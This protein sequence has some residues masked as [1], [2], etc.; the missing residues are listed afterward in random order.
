MDVTRNIIRYPWEDHGNVRT[1][2][3]DEFG[4]NEHQTLKSF[5]K[6]EQG[7]IVPYYNNTSCQGDSYPL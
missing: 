3:I 1:M 5:R 6:I 2:D 7:Q 4:E